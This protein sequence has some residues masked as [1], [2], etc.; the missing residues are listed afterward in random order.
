M[1]KVFYLI[2]PY[3]HHIGIMNAGMPLVSWEYHTTTVQLLT[4][5]DV[6]WPTRPSFPSKV[7][8]RYLLGATL[9]MFI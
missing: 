9:F 6:E 2:I 1:V 8:E 5:L 7:N 3:L 4:I